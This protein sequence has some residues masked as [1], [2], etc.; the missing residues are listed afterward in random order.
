MKIRLGFVSNSSS[1]SYIVTINKNFLSLEALL[2]DIYDS[3]WCAIQEAEADYFERREAYEERHPQ[4]P[5]STTI[6]KSVFDFI[7]AHHA[8]RVRRHTSNEGNHREYIDNFEQK[9][10]STLY[11]L[12]VEGITVQEISLGKYTLTNFTSMHNSFNDMNPLLKNIYLE[13]LTQNGGANFNF[14]SNN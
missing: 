2:A 13:Y 10:E 9:V 3:C 11:T 4:D 1:T 12:N 7:P 14:E 5:N 6:M 8:P